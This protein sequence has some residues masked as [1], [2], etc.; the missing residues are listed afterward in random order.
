LQRVSEGTVCRDRLIGIMAEPLEERALLAKLRD[1]PRERLAEVED[2][3]DF[4]REREADR[5]LTS[6]MTS[7]SEEAFREVWD[8]PADAAYDEL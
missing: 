4:L 8:N 3:V 5:Q 2:F 6:R 7:L 1:L